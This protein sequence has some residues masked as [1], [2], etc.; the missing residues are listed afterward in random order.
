M[1][2]VEMIFLSISLN[3]FGSKAENWR[4][5][6]GINDPYEA[7]VNPTVECLT[8][9]GNGGYCVVKV[10]NKLELGYCNRLLKVRAV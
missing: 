3:S 7:P 6:R 2:G 8:D 9:A 5:C 10:L 4:F 1:S